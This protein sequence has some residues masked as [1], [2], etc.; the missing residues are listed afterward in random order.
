MAFVPPAPQLPGD[1]LLEIFVYPNP[2]L[3]D[4]APD[5]HNKFSDCARL[6][7]LGR[8]M[9][10]LAYMDAMAQ[11]SPNATGEHLKAMIASR[12]DSFMARVAAAYQ[13][14]KQVRGYP[15]GFNTQKS[16][17]QEAVRLFRI[18]AGAVH[19]EYGYEGLKRWIADLS[20][21]VL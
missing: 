11:R 2:I 15:H 19:V 17:L 20:A 21:T 5:P 12:L 4:Q 7:Y 18:Y 16:D 10:E 3:Q 14:H 9:T 6:E 13:W 1:A 8:Q